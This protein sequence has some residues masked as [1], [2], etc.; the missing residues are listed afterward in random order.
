MVGN[1]ILTFVLF[2]FSLTDTNKRDTCIK[3]G[4]YKE[5]NETNRSR[6]CCTYS[7]QSFS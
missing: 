6:T 7:T 2:Y 4:F 1:F 5:I 3:Y